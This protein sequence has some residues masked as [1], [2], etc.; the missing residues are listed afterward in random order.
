MKST[1]DLAGRGGVRTVAARWVFCA[2]L[3]LE[4]P[5][6]FGGTGQD[7]ADMM[8]LRD[9]RSGSPLL[10]G[11][12]M[13]G[14]LR[15]YLQAVLAGYGYGSKEFNEDPRI[16]KLFGA[17][18]GDD[19][20]PQSPLIFFDSIA[21]VPDES[22]ALI[23]EIRDGIQIDSS[24][25]V[26]AD[27]KKFDYEVL[28]AGTTFPFRLDLV[29]RDPQDEP[30]LISLLAACLEGFQSG[31]VYLGARRSR[32]FGRVRVDRWRVRRFDLTTREGWLTWLC[33]KPEQPFSG[34]GQIDAP[35][36]C[37]SIQEAIRKALPQL[38]MTR[39]PDSRARVTAEIELQ[40]CGP[41]LVGSPGTEADAPDRTHLHSA[42]RP[43][44]PATSLVGALR[45]RA[46]K[47][48]RLVREPQADADKW[49]DR[50]FGYATDGALTLQGSKPASLGSR[51]FVSEGVIEGGES[52]R[53]SRVNIDRFTQGVVKHRLFDEQV[54]HG[55]RARI[56]LELRAPHDGEVGLLLLVLKD[57]LSGDISIGGTAGVG[58]GRVRGS[59][60][61]RFLL[62]SYPEEP[63]VLSVDEAEQSQEHV[64]LLD[65][66]IRRFVEAAPIC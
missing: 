42:G 9:K 34:E 12:S 31:E 3:I 32:G 5:A 13:A 2:D 14:A 6:H 18:K 28:P 41:M 19:T 4:S 1:R 20:G 54:H 40:L 39:Y 17:A 35:W 64:E 16:A 8:L 7:V 45:N 11:A 60:T 44:L 57:L 50:L 27:H 22:S 53:P 63:I 65:N 10:P 59:G 46:T 38:E 30:E 62:P 36:V 61:L 24:S 55:G 49:I 66:E 25:G 29:V 47:I 15:E 33:T 56:H 37:A 52:Y 51:L 26:A 21:R 23:S 48:A 43:V 58:R